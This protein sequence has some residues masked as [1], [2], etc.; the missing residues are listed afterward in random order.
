MT[1]SLTPRL[2]SAKEAAAYFQLPVR[3]F[4]RL[5]IGRVCF[6][7]KVLYDRV[8]LDSY[9]DGVSGLDMR[10]EPHPPHEPEAALAR[11]TA[12]LESPSGRPPRP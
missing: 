9:L 7:A 6:G 12:H 3:R 4:E 10:Q 1:V 2:L 5:H 11:F 8:A